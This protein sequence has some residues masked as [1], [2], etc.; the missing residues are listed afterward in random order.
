MHKQTDL[1]RQSKLYR[2]QS[3][4]NFERGVQAVFVLQNRTKTES[5]RLFKRLTVNLTTLT[6]LHSLAVD[7]LSN[8]PHAATQLRQTL[9]DIGRRFPKYHGSSRVLMDRANF[10][11]HDNPGEWFDDMGRPPSYPRC[12]GIIT[13]E[14]MAEIYIGTRFAYRS[15]PVEFRKAIDVI[16][17]LSQGHGHLEV[18]HRRFAHEGE[19]G[20]E[21]HIGAE[22]VTRNPFYDFGVD[23]YDTIPE[24]VL[25]PSGDICEQT[26]IMCEGI[27]L[28]ALTNT[29]PPSPATTSTWAD[30]ITKLEFPQGKCTG[31]Q[32]IIHGQDFGNTQPTGVDLVMYINCRCAVVDIEPHNWHDTQITVTLPRGVT[33]GPVG[34]H[35]SAGLTAYNQW[36]A[37]VNQSTQTIASASQCLGSPLDMPRLPEAVDSICPPRTRFNIAKVGKPCIRS[38]KV[39]IN[40]KL[41]SKNIVDP[42]DDLTLIWDVV[43]GDDITLKRVSST[44]PK[45]NGETTIDVSASS[46]FN[47]GSPSHHKPELF[48]YQICAK[49]DCGEVTK[50]LKIYGSKRPGLTIDMIEVTQGVQSLDHSV[51]LVANKPTLVRVFADHNVDDFDTGSGADI[52]PEVHG[53]IQLHLEN[54]NTSIWLAPINNATAEPPNL[55]ESSATAKIDLPAAANRRRDRTNDT[56]NFI[57]PANLC[58]GTIRIEVEIFVDNYASVVEGEMRG[59]SERVSFISDDEYNF[60]ESKPIE[61]KYIPVEVTGPSDTIEIAEDISNPPSKEECEKLIREALQFLPTT[62][63]SISK[64]EQTVEISIGTEINIS[65][66]TPLGPVSIPYKRDSLDFD[67]VATLTLE[68]FRAKHLAD[69][70]GAYWVLMVPTTGPWG[71]ANW[72]PSFECL[73][74]MGWHE[75]YNDRWPSWSS[76][77]AHVAH[78]LAHCLNQYHLTVCDAADFP[79]APNGESDPASWPNGGQILNNGDDSNDDVVPFNIIQNSVVSNIEEGVVWDLMTYCVPKWTSPRRWQWLFDY[80]VSSQ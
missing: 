53:R 45:F 2:K 6:Y 68:W 74:S 27:L 55:P 22:I 8:N 17:G 61:I 33:Q 58:E 35:N 41:Q 29:I 12:G 23:V 77:A 72:V 60:L 1:R 71:R 49:N 70:D 9:N 26:R 38:F 50:T 43:N 21:R 34:F 19:T 20:L 25:Y 40:D 65:V 37:D 39:K 66:D 63:S 69:M 46:E 13:Y 15:Q 79:P 3:L 5:R 47:L 11:P 64:L 54:G 67:I 44:G 10:N 16:A 42:T 59:F 51:L 4:Q 80:I 78:E 18:A 73:V 75:D 76:P 57:I 56:L 30:N 48:E 62:A 52:V 31:D 32:M 36:V 24:E 28:D 14:G 7:T